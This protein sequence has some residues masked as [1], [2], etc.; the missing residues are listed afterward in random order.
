MFIHENM[1]INISLLLI[2]Y[3]ACQILSYYILNSGKI[4]YE[5]II[6]LSLIIICYIIFGY[7]TYNPIKTN[8]FLDTK[9]NIYGINIK[10]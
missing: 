1:F 3:I 10:K 2:T 4:K 7:L 9:K 6:G 8:L 5:K